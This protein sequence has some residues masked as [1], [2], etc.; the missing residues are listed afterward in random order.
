MHFCFLLQQS[1]ENKV[2]REDFT[3]LVT[4]VLCDHFAAQFTNPNPG[5]NASSLFFSPTTIVNFFLEDTES[6]VLRRMRRLS[7]LQ[8]HRCFHKTY[9]VTDYPLNLIVS[10]KK[11]PSSR[12]R[13]STFNT[14]L[15][16]C[17][18]C[19][20]RSK[21]ISHLN[22]ACALPADV[23]NMFY[24]SLRLKKVGRSTV[25]LRATRLLDQSHQVDKLQN[26]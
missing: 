17:C 12:R 11:P 15:V 7:S 3:L 2:I 4:C 19:F 6:S 16:G 18:F 9:K 20:C 14:L 25:P 10:V 1:L 21:S 23:L 24:G 13:S 26:G 8:I 5:H 22:M